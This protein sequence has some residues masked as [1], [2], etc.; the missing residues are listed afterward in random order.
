MPDAASFP[1]SPSQDSAETA[2]SPDRKTSSYDKDLITRTLE[3]IRQTR[4]LLDATV[5]SPLYRRPPNGEND[6]Q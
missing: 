3:T 1:V 2:K 4:E 6:D 5:P